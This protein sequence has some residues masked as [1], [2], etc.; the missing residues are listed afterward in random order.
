[1][2]KKMFT[3]QLSMCSKLENAFYYH[4]TKDFTRQLNERINSKK[5]SISLLRNFSL[6]FVDGYESN[7]YKKK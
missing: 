1:M 3:R 4:T 7:L 6:T 5:I 2:F